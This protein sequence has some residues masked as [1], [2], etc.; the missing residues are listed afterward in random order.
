MGRVKRYAPYKSF[1]GQRYGR[2]ISYDTKQEA[3][4][5][6]KRLRQQGDKVRITKDKLLTGKTIYVTWLRK[7]Y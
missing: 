3:I 5:H 7:G 1:G 6:A 4:A 2:N